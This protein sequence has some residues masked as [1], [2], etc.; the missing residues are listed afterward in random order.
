MLYAQGILHHHPTAVDEGGERI[1][2]C[3]SAC[4]ECGQVSAAFADA[5]LGRNDLASLVQC[6]RLNLACAGI[7]GATGRILSRMSTSCRPA[8][9]RTPSPAGSARRGARGRPARLSNARRSSRRAGNV[10][11]PAWPSSPVS[12]SLKCNRRLPLLLILHSASAA[13]AALRLPP[14]LASDRSRARD[15][16]THPPIDRS[17]RRGRA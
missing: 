1:G 7:C 10:K 12:N 16:S 15:S 14:R 17:P 6:V 2:S 3:I 13:S 11:T 5:C 8:W 4:F 9:T